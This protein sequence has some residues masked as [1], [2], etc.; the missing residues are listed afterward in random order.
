VNPTEICHRIN[1]LRKE[2]RIGEDETDRWEAMAKSIGIKRSS[3]YMIKKRNGVTR[4]FFEGIVKV[5]VRDGLDINYVLTG[6]HCHD[7]PACRGEKG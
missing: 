7:L 1:D 5:C 4:E 2:S 3:L 6:V